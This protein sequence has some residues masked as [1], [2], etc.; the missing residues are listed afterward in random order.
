MD[1]YGKTVKIKELA[2]I[3]EYWAPPEI[4]RKSRQRI[5]TVKVTPEGTSLGEMA[6]A[7]QAVV[8]K[9]DI[10][11]GI[12]TDF[13]GAYEDQQETFSDM[14][15]LLVM[16]IMLVYIVMAS[17]FEDFRNPLI[18]M[19]SAVFALPGVIFMLL[20]TNT[21]LDMI[22]ALGMILLVGIVVKNGIVLVD[23]INL[24]RERGYELKE[25]IALSGASRLR[26]VLMTAMTTIL[27]MV[28]MAISSSEGSEMWRPMGVVVIGGLTV[29]TF[30]TLIIVPVLYGIVN[31]HG[32]EEKLAKR[33]KNF[34]FMQLNADA[35]K[36][37][38]TTITSETTEK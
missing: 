4:K 35:N 31:K 7:M 17:Q 34:I 18:I 38:E 24:M 15:V 13:G 20:V 10:P 3:H 19:I 14:A 36:S 21:N 37:S 6:A 11:L 23:Y 9:T 22:G 32:D 1:A 5:V 28:P 12:H 2:E 25:A 16:I 8:D 26:P 27:G 29:A 30:I 33:R